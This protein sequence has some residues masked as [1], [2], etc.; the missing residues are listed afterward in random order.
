MVL[1]LYLRALDALFAYN[2][3]TDGDGCGLRQP[4]LL[5]DRFAIHTLSVITRLK[6]RTLLHDNTSEKCGT[7]VFGLPNAEEIVRGPDRPSWVLSQLSRYANTSNCN[8]S[9]QSS[10]ILSSTVLAVHCNLWGSNW[11]AGFGGIE[12]GGFLV[13]STTC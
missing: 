6:L 13:T 1:G 5:Q 8:S 3:P 11:S 9:R 10:T 2:D 12:H 4:S 7:L